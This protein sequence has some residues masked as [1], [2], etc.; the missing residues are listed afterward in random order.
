MMAFGGTLVVL[1]L[2]GAAF[3]VSD[4]AV[5]GDADAIWKSIIGALAF[6]PAVWLLVGL[7]AVFIGLMPRAS[8]LAWA[9]LGVCFVIGMFGQLLHLPRAM[10]EV[11]PFQHIPQFPAT[12]LEIW[13]LVALVAIA[14]GLTALGLAGLRRRDIG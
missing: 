12:D 10:L 11:S 3:G 14:A 13:P 4:A 6:A 8:M 7:T 5:T 9:V 2:I 1:F